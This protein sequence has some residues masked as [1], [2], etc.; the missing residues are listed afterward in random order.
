MRKPR[1]FET[2]VRQRAKAVANSPISNKMSA[3]RH[4][5]GARREGRMV[6][7]E[8][9]FEALSLMQA[10]FRPGM[11]GPPPDRQTPETRERIAQAVVMLAIH[12]ERDPAR[13]GAW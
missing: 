10:M 9:D 3:D 8:F 12:W 13:P 6:A 5:R 4:E 11:G 1:E 2:T 7:G